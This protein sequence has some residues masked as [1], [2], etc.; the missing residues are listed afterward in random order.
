MVFSAHAMALSD[1]KDSIRW[2]HI[3]DVLRV[4]RDF[5]DQL[6]SITDKQRYNREASKDAE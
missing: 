4:T 5:Q 1:G 6:K 2:T 3:R